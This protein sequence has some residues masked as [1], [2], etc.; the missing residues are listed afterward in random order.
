MT[1]NQKQIREQAKF[2][3]SPFGKAFEKQL[4]ATEDQGEKQ[5]KAI[6][7]QGQVK[8]IKKYPYDDEDNPLISKQKQIFDKLIHPRFEEI[9]NLDKN[10]NSDDSIYRYKA[11]TDANFGECDTAFILL[12]KIRDGKMSLADAKIDQAEIKSNQSE[13]EKET[14]NIDQK[15]K[16]L[17]CIILKCFAKLGIVLLNFLMIIL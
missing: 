17:N 7:N 2:T 4:K 11:N 12:D 6:Q 1:S 16:K 15:S 5:I 3:Y 14:K 10:V 8:T 13:I 9:T